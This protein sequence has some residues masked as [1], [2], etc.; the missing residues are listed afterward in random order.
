MDLNL[1]DRRSG[2]AVLATLL[3]LW[4]YI[5]MGFLLALLA[6]TN[7]NRPPTSAPTSTI[8][9]NTLLVSTSSSNGLQSAVL[10]GEP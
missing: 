2:N 10:E 6:V 1:K 4:P 8:V 3:R 5:A 9:R 7:L